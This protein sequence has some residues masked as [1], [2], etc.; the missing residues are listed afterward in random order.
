MLQV[1]HGCREVFFS[2]ILLSRSGHSKPSR[3]P[4]LYTPHQQKNLYLC[5]QGWMIKVDAVPDT[6]IKGAPEKLAHSTSDV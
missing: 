6:L 4:V 5:N 1:R 3:T 2:A